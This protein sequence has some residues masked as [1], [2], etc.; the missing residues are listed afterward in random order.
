MLV[1]ASSRIGFADF[2]REFVENVMRFAGWI[3]ASCS[4]GL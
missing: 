3:G 4:G 1:L 2:G